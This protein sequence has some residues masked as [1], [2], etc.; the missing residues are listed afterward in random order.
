MLEKSL[1]VLPFSGKPD[2]WNKW[3]EKFQGIASHD[4]YDAVLQGDEKPLS[5][6]VVASAKIAGMALTTEEKN[7]HEMN[8]KAYTNML[9]AMS[10]EAFGL[11]PDLQDAGVV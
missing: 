8:Q 2:D 4:G 3:S 5:D 11:G 7:V 10:G 9:L 6:S 1:K